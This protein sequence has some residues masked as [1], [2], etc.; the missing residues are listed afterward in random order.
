MAKNKLDKDEKKALEAHKDALEKSF[1]KV[2]EAIAHYNETLKEKWEAVQIAVETY[3]TDVVAAL[4]FA[5]EIASDLRDSHDEG[6][7]KWQ[8]S[9]KGEAHES[10]VQEWENLS[11]E[12]L[13]IDEP[14]EIDEQTNE[15]Y[16]ALVLLPTETDG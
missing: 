13:N 12:E 14:D 2:E 3:N 4:D 5:T 15:P 11:L 10:F 16:D 8:A 1:S 7:E 9:E 6:S